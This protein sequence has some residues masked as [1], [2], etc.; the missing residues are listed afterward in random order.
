M[1]LSQSTVLQLYHSVIEDVVTNVRESFLDDGVDE[2]VLQELKQIWESKLQ[3]TKAVELTPEPQ[4]PQNVGMARSGGIKLGGVKRPAGPSG[5]AEEH[6]SNQAIATDDQSIGAFRSEKLFPVQITLPAQQGSGET[7]P[8]VLTI[9]VP[10][11]AITGNHLQAVLTG[12]LIG[13][14]LALPTALATSVLQQ[15][16][17]AALR[18]QQTGSLL[19]SRPFN[20]QQDNSTA[21]Q[22]DGTF[23]SNFLKSLPL[24][25]KGPAH[26][27]VRTGL[28]KY[29]IETVTSSKYPE[30]VRQV[31]G[32]IDTSDEDDDDIDDEEEEKEEEEE[33]D[34]EPENLEGAVEEEPLNSGDDVSDEDVSDLFDTD[35]VVVCQFDKITRSRNKW[36]FYLKDGI[37]NLSGK[38]FVFQR[39]NGDAE[40]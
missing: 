1:S 25:D 19:A 36:K 40:W 18:G 35:N 4:E 16:V 13:A 22:V 21:S 14:T 5:D 23:D 17:T 34:E 26:V 10:E 37:M 39:S 27:V 32:G 31:D 11:S 38:D 9:Q 20:V 8:R 3:S 24:A 29:S 15:H 33:K 30:S 7:G 2:Q 12:P 6:S 28:F